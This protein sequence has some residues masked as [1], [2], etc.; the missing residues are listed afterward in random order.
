MHRGIAKVLLLAIPVIFLA[1]LGM[2]MIMRWREGA[3]RIRCQDNL[4]RLGWFAMW[5]Y[6]DRDFAFPN[7][8]NPADRVSLLPEKGLP[9]DR[10]FPSGTIANPSLT[11][12]HRLSWQVMLLPQIAQDDVYKQFDLK[13]AWD[14]DA[15][16]AAVLAKVVTLA[17]PT[18]YIVPVPGEP[19]LAAYVGMAGLGPDAANLPPDN[20]Q[21]GFFHYDEPTKTGHLKRGV[22]NTM[23]MLESTRDRG[24]WAAGARPTLRG[25]D[26]AEQSYVGDGRQFGAHPAGCNVAYADGSVRFMANSIDPHVFEMLVMLADR[27]EK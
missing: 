20:P 11:P 26:P 21:A 22:S 4:R 7:G 19:Q 17:C 16:R 18:T 25:V 12:D 9:P 1:G 2:I 23:T 3:N 13:K 5:Q 24:P 27:R 14:D 10:A 8:V 6:T 15:N